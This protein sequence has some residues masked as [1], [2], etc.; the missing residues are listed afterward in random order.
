MVLIPALA[1]APR[2]K[3]FIIDTDASSATWRWRAV[4]DHHSGTVYIA[5]GELLTHNE[6][7]KRG[8]VAVDMN[9]LTVSTVR[10]LQRNALVT[11]WMKG[12]EVFDTYNHPRVVFRLVSVWRESGNNYTLNGSLTIKGKTVPVRVPAVVSFQKKKIDI[13]AQLIVDQA[14]FNLNPGSAASNT[15]SSQNEFKLQLHLVAKRD[16]VLIR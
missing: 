8:N 13:T 11:G 4:S 12:K 15:E 1:F 16:N 6:E 9:S 10:D 2:P 5:S 7:I 14:K 3:T